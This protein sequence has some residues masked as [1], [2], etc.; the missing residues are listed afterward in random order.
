MCQTRIDSHEPKNYRRSFPTPNL[1][2]K[3]TRSGLAFLVEREG[4]AGPVHVC[5]GDPHPSR[6]MSSTLSS[7]QNNLDNLGSL[8]QDVSLDVT[9]WEEEGVSLKTKWRFR[10]VLGLP[11]NPTLAA[12]G[13][14]VCWRHEI[15]CRQRLESSI[16]FPSWIEASF[17]DPVARLRRSSG[18]ALVHSR[19][20]EPRRAQVAVVG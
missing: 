5:C 7:A 18:H 14:S 20:C 8:M 17:V 1:L 15:G 6:T 12:A 16:G 3:T 9:S 11:W 13:V 19:C 2:T 4:H 10:C